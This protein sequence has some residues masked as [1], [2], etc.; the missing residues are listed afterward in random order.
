MQTF[1]IITV[2]QCWSEDRGDWQIREANAYAAD[3]RAGAQQ[4]A[5]TRAQRLLCRIAEGEDWTIADQH[6]SAIGNEI[7]DF[8]IEERTP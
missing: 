6:T 3:D 1:T 8:R 5:A 2:W 7:H 4:L